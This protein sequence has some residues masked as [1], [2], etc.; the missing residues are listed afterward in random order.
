MTTVEEALIFSGSRSGSS[1]NKS[2]RVSNLDGLRGV[3]ILVVLFY[4]TL[5][6]PTAGFVGV[7]L[8]FVLSGFLISGILFEQLFVR[9]SIDLW[10]FYKARCLRLIPAFLVLYLLYIFIS[11]EFVPLG[12]VYPIQLAEILFLT[13]FWMTNG[14]F[15]HCWTLSTEW[16]FYFVWPAVLVA[17]GR[18]GLGQKAI[19]FICVAGAV[20]TW[21]GRH[22]AGLN[23]RFDGLILGAILALASRN[24]A[25]R[26]L[27]QTRFAT[28]AIASAGIGFLAAAFAPSDF[29][30]WYGLEFVEVCSG[31]LVLFSYYSANPAVTAVLSNSVLVYIGRVSYGLYLFHWPI[32]GAVRYVDLDPKKVLFLTIP[33][34]FFVAHLS[35]VFVEQPIM[36]VFGQ[37]PKQLAPN[38]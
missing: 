13:N 5:L 16:Q 36:R 11:K 17:V 8:F 6:V 35:W 23:L 4:H 24:G 9:G 2:G 30:T 22:Y 37:K 12:M 15:M 18:A 31:T 7:D 1:V 21:A 10:Q 32:S 27:A 14:F 19:L 38:I 28:A 34:T 25:V 3:A 20:L 29:V 26:A 33:L